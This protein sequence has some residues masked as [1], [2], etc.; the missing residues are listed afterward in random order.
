[1][2]INSCSI[3]MGTDGSGTGTDDR[4]TF[5]DRACSDTGSTRTGT[6]TNSTCTGSDA[7]VMGIVGTSTGTNS[8]DAVFLDWS[9]I[10]V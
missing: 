10:A 1:M 9:Y 7:V 5:T 8:R 4:K 3:D 2:L 6:W